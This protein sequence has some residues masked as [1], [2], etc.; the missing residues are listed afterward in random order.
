MNAPAI[1]SIMLVEDDLRLSELVS[2]YLEN[3]GFRLTTLARGDRVLE[4]VQRDPP[5]LIILDLGLPDQDGFSICR[6]LRPG[7]G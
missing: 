1:P 2:R 6:Q 5:D 3:N 4:Q 7:G